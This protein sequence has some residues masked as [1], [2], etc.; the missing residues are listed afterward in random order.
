MILFCG[1]IA[2]LTVNWIWVNLPFSFMGLRGRQAVLFG[3]FTLLQTFLLPHPYL[4]LWITGFL[5][6]AVST[7]LLL[8]ANVGSKRY[9]GIL[10]IFSGVMT[11]TLTMLIMWRWLFSPNL[12]MMYTLGLVCG[13]TPIVLGFIHL[14]VNR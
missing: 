7:A 3:D 12:V 9:V 4:A 2:S 13:L 6:Q 14:I 1:S 5:S 8:P 11:T 10:L